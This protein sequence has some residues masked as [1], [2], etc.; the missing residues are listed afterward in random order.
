MEKLHPS[1]LRKPV[2]TSERCV[3]EDSNQPDKPWVLHLRPASDTEMG[4]ASD[5]FHE[6]V[7]RFIRGSWVDDKGKVHEKPDI[8]YSDGEILIFSESLLNIACK[9]FVMQDP[10]APDEERYDDP[11][12]ILELVDFYPEAWEN[13]CLKYLELSKRP[14]AL[15]PGT[16]EK[17]PEA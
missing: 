9:L 13:I 15:T 16:S 11:I 7:T 4:S 10:N 6:Y 3:F 1:K 5:I 8:H 17:S 14:K 12:D 2:R